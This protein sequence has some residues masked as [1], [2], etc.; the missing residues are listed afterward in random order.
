M[1]ELEKE[2]KSIYD[3]NE[4]VNSIYGKLTTDNER[5]RLLDIIQNKDIEVDYSRVIMIAYLI[6]KGEEDE[7]IIRRMA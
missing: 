7:D 6:G 3:S 2:L 4:F 5:K 1:A